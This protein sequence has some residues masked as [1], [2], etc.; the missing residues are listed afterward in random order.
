MQETGVKAGGLPQTET[1]RRHLHCS[2]ECV[3]KGDH[4]RN[5]LQGV[6]L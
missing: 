6:R 5:Q 1:D 2:L 4:L 3:L